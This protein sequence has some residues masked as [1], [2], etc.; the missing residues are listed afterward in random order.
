MHPSCRII[1][2]AAMGSSSHAKTALAL[3]PGQFSPDQQS[4]SVG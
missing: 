3:G 4:P 1:T 2:A